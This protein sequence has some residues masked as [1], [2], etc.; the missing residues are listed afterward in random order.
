[1]IYFIVE[2]ASPDQVK[3]GFSKNSKTLKDRISQLQIGNSSK[4]EVLGI[5]DGSMGLEKRLHRIMDDYWISGEW[6]SLCE[7]LRNYIDKNTKPW[8]K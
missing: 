7:P 2:K 1:M 8:A 6:F 4:L 5:M 3:I